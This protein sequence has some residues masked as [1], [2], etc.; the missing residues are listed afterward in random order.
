[1]IGP[2]EVKKTKHLTRGCRKTQ[3]EQKNRKMYVLSELLLLLLLL[4]RSSQ[5]IFKQPIVFIIYY[6]AFSAARHL[7]S[8][9]MIFSSA[10]RHG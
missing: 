4:H 2:P 6:L 1:L 7:G 8:E 9:L 5:I 3:Q 10:D